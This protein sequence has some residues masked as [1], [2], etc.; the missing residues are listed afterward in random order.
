MAGKGGGDTGKSTQTTEVKL[1]EWVNQ[2]SQSNYARAQD[3][4]NRPYVANP[5][6]GEA[7]V[8]PWT[9]AQNQGAA[10]LPQVGQYQSAY[11]SAQ[12]A[13][14]GLLGYN[15]TQIQAGRVNAGQLSNTDL[16]PYMNPFTG[17]VEANTVRQMN[18][19]GTRAQNQ[20]RADAAK[21]GSFGGS[22]QA[23]QQGV[24]QAETAKN[25]GDTVS[26][27]RS[28][29]FAQAQAAAK[30]DL[31]RAL[32]GDTTNLQNW[33][34]VQKQNV[35][36]QLAAKGI[37]KDAANSL[38]AAATA[39]QE[40]AIK[41]LGQYMTVGSMQQAQQQKVLDAKSGQWQQQQDY[42]LEQLNILLS[43]L[44]MSPYGKTETT[45]K[46]SEQ[47][48]GSDFGSMLGG[49]GSILGTV[50]PLIAA[51]DPSM[52]T[53]VQKMG[54]DGESGL[55]MYAYRYKGDPKSYPKVVGPMATDVKKKAPKLVKSFGGKKAIDLTHLAA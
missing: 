52:K 3:V 23:V 24:Q 35:A 38:V 7:S 31:D 41:T 6:G 2:A 30:S 22:R 49:F 44:G 42:P 11:G 36:N 18:E 15:P 50:G 16:T 28:A 1:P 9:A 14:S 53:D 55:D 39:G 34:D 4:A 5:Y 12:D 47:K 19:A 48:G 29:N 13:L 27:L 54:K 17:E 37:Q 45:Q 26:Q 8:A 51:S 40:S 33:T 20:I 10:M 43:S 25:I 46:T 32:T 21:G